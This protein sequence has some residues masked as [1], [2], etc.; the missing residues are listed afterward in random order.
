MAIKNYSPKL[1]INL[2]EDS[3]IESLTSEYESTKQ[4]FKTILLTNPGEKLFNRRFGVGI[5]KFLFQTIRDGNYLEYKKNNLNEKIG[6][7]LILEDEL[8]SLIQQNISEFLPEISN[9]RVTIKES[10]EVK[11]AINVVI[12]YKF[13]SFYQDSVEFSISGM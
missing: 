9:V 10:T 6:E 12:Y 3:S 4:K 11:N 5:K 2:K 1:P 8:Q 7:E 13:M